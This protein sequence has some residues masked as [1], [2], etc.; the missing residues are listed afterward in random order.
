MLLLIA[1]PVATV[2]PSNPTEPPNPTVKGAVKMEPNI[3][4]CFIIPFR[5][6]MEKSVEGIP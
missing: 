2:G 3:W 6:E 4:Y 1:E 5:L